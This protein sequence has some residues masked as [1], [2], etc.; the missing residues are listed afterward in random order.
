[1][2]FSFG[3][4]LAAHGRAGDH[5]RR[6][7]AC[8]M[9]LASLT[10][11]IERVFT[12]RRSRSASRAFAAR[13]PPRPAGGE[14]RRDPRRRRRAQARPPGAHR[15]HRRH[16]LLARLQ[17]ARHLG[18]AAGRAHPAPPR[19]LHRGGRRRP[20]SRPRG[21]GVGRLGGAVRRPARH[22]GRHHL[23]LPGHRGDRLGRPVVGVG[24]HQRG[25]HRDRPRPRG[26]DP[27]GARLQLPHQR[28]RPRRGRARTARRASCSTRSRTG[29]E[30]SGTER[31]A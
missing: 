20:A 23:G 21:A 25:A 28:D 26:R 11:F 14:R 18:A 10:V 24:R 30:R 2:S 17:H 3:E 1:M 13:S 19:A 4:I 7:P 9:G 5:R 16:D 6:D 31:S 8:V 29:Q 27:G 22:R 12:L 15:P